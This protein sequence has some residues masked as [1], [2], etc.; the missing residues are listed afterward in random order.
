MANNTQQFPPEIWHKIFSYFLPKINFNESPLPLFWPHDWTDDVPVMAKICLVSRHLDSI[1]RPFLYRHIVNSQS[2]KC[3]LLLR[4]LSKN[5]SLGLHVRRFICSEETE[6]DPLALLEN[7]MWNLE[8]QAVARAAMSWWH[9][10]ALHCVD[11]VG[12][13]ELETLELCFFISLMPNLEL[14]HA[15]V[16]GDS[17]LLSWLFAQA[18]TTAAMSS[19]AALHSGM[20]QTGE[21]HVYRSHKEVPTFLTRLR[22][23]HLEH[24]DSENASHVS[25]KPALHLP[26]LETFDG[27]MLRWDTTDITDGS[28]H[29]S[30]G[31]H[32]DGDTQVQPRQSDLVQAWPPNS[33]LRIVNLRESEITLEM[34]ESIFTCCPRLEHLLIQWGGGGLGQDGDD[35]DLNEL[36][37]ILRRWGRGLVSLLV[38]S[39]SIDIRGSI[40]DLRQLESL[41]ELI[42]TPQALCGDQIDNGDPV[43]DGDVDYIGDRLPASLESLSLL[44][45]PFVSL[46]SRTPQMLVKPVLTNRRLS[47]LTNVNIIG[48]IDPIVDVGEAGWTK[49]VGAYKTWDTCTLLTRK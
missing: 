23:L 41:R 21:Y 39:R 5:P 10:K 18:A 46:P 31:S 14:L 35:T 34:I 11:K 33:T 48:R 22:E 49:E 47:K 36:G 37:N 2:D 25:F 38:D 43:T 40:R 1:C 6:C 13:V 42:I 17:A 3:G 29:Q 4:T 28:P 26:R 45:A 16:P 8:H 12:N 19:G 20:S 9:D 7:G 24:W 27:F 44:L 15:V 30:W 32:L